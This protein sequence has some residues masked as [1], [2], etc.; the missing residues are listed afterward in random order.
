VAVGLPEM[1]PLVALKVAVEAPAATFTDA[2]TV[3]AAWF[4]ESATLAPPVGASWVKVIVQV[5]VELFPKAVGVQLSDATCTGATRLTLEVLAT[6]LRVAV[7]VAVWLE[8]QW[9]AVA[10]EVAEAEPAGTVTE[11]ATESIEL[12]LDSATAVPPLG[13]A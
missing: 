9:P 5:L 6:P 1:V 11:A 10:V 3:S 12:L 8:P 2:G 4:E 13:A 7:T